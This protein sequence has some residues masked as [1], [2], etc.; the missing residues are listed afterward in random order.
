[1]APVPSR[2]DEVV[3]VFVTIGGTKHFTNKLQVFDI[4]PCETGVLAISFDTALGNVSFVDKNE[5]DIR[6]VDW[7]LDAVS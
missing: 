4:R 6:T 2:V 7:F 1:V 3:F 5:T